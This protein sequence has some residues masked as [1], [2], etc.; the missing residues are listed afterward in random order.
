MQACPDLKVEL[1]QTINRATE[2]SCKNQHLGGYWVGFLET[3]CTMEA[4][5]ILGMHI[6][7]VSDDPK[8]EG[9]LKAIRRMQRPDGAWGVYHEAES[10]DMNATVEC[11][12]ALRASGDAA[13]LPHMVKARE[14]IL[15]HG[16]VQSCRVF[17]KIWL[18]MLGEWPWDGTPTLPPEIV[19]FPLKFPFSLY[20]FASW[21]RATIVPLTL[22]SA[23]RPVRPLPP[24]CTLDELFPQGRKGR[25]THLPR[26]KGF[27][28]AKFFWIADKA[29]RAYQKYAPVKPLRQNAIKNC[30]EWILSRQEADGCWAGIQP[31]WIYSLMAL[32]FEGYALDHPV[33]K[34]GIRCFDA[35]WP[36][37]TSAAPS[38]RPAPRR[39]GIPCS[40]SW[41]CSIAAGIAPRRLFCNRWNTS[42]KS[43]SRLPATGAR[44]CPTCREAAG[45]SNMRTTVIPTSTTRP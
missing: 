2:W 6:L 22:I 45:P 16:G 8:K 9:V 11:Y 40:P 35:P 34:A 42:S 38:C 21:A 32:R 44:K 31:P 33:L 25:H 30:L 3:N 15:S 4:E 19:F 29:L 13:N 18:A 24:G 12:A 36:K 28:W 37:T 23:R 39:S 43:R 27:G 41:L 17:T 1:E 5:W 26:P 7:G 14:W 20:N 10:G